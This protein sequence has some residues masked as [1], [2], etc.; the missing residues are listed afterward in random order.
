MKFSYTKK[1]NYNCQWKKV[2]IFFHLNATNAHAINLSNEIAREF[3]GTFQEYDVML[4]LPLLR[5]Y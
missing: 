3:W 4:P 1:K 2:A 5:T